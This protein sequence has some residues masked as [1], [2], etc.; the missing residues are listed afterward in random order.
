MG[1]PVVPAAVTLPS[2][3]PTIVV[4]SSSLPPPDEER[5]LRLQALLGIDKCELQTVFSDN[6]THL[7][8]PAKKGVAQKRSL[9][10]IQAVLS[11][12][13]I[14]RPECASFCFTHLLR[15]VL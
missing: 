4:L 10:Y 12:V 15:S 8:V 6:I 7:V 2:I 14:V 1:A 9:K 5:L 3:A 11:K 13:Y